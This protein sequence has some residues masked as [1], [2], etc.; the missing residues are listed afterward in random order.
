MKKKEEKEKS[1]V[2]FEL[3]EETSEEQQRKNQPPMPKPTEPK[4]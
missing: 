4:E 1:P 3:N 2:D